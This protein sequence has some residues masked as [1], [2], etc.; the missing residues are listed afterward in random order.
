[1]IYNNNGETWYNFAEIIDRIPSQINLEN[2]STPNIWGVLPANFPL[3]FG[4]LKLITSFAILMS[5]N[6]ITKNNIIDNI[7]SFI[8][9]TNLHTYYD[10]LYKVLYNKYCDEYCI[11]SDILYQYSEFN[12]FNWDVSFNESIYTF[13][14]RFINILDRTKE[15]YKIL[16]DAY[17][18]NKSNLMTKLEEKIKN[19]TDGTSSSIGKFND[20]PQGE[21]VD[22]RYEQDDHLTSLNQ[23]SGTTHGEGEQTRTYQIESL[24]NQLNN[25]ENKLNDII[26]KWANEF[27]NLFI[28]DYNL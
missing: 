18:N 28:T 21:F 16:I 2:E 15:R 11:K 6:G 24:M 26:N 25:V 4:S 1:M 14:N 13:F 7:K 27:S 9:Y 17:E 8:D 5:R 19:E 10:N 12:T 20:T 3:Q 22:G 23:D